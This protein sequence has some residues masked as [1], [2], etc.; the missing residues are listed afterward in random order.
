MKALRI[1]EVFSARKG[2]GTAATVSSAHSFRFR[3]RVPM[4][5]ATARQLI[6]YCS[7]P[8]GQVLAAYNGY[9]V[10]VGQRTGVLYFDRT[11]PPGR[12]RH[13]VTVDFSSSSFYGPASAA[14][15]DVINRLPFEPLPF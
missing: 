10:R 6:T 8:D 12:G 13:Q 1:A 7:D 4:D 9:T 15:Q 11:V 14:C 5:V 3:G 2:P